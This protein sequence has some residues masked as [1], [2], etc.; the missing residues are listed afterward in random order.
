MTFLSLLTFLLP[1]VLFAIAGL[2]GYWG[3]GG[4]WPGHDEVSLARTVVG[5]KGITRMASPTACFA[6]TVLLIG[7]GLWPLFMAGVLPAFWPHWLTLLAGWG[8]V[9]VFFGRGLA[10]YVPAFRL[11]A[12]EEPFASLDRQLYGPLCLALGGGFLLFLL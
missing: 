4:L 3:L 7:V 1:L 10:A 11:L 8:F 9:L 5:S 2:H 12:P 6:V